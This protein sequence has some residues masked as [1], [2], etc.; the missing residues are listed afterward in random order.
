MFFGFRSHQ[1]SL[2][3]ADYPLPIMEIGTMPTSLN[4][5]KNESRHG[6]LGALVVQSTS[7]VFEHGPPAEQEFHPRW[8]RGFCIPCIEARFLF[9]AKRIRKRD[10]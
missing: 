1:K 9:R 4:F 10:R 5:L 7:S 3:C 8:D 2:S 6:A